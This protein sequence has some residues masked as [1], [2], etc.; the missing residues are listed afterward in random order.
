MHGV[1]WLGPAA[2]PDDK[3]A[4][5]FGSID[6]QGA[7]AHEFADDAGSWPAEKVQVDNEELPCVLAL[8]GFTY[9]RLSRGAQQMRRPAKSGSGANR[10]RTSVQASGRSLSSSSS[11]C[12]GRWGMRRTPWR[13]AISRNIVGYGADR[14]GATPCHGSRVL[15]SLAFF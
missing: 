14:N 5:F 13:S 7:H 4:K 12:S 9:N 15:A 6:L 2:P 8:D 11:R 1:L 3:D 10:R